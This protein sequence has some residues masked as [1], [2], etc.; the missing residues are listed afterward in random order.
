MVLTANWRNEIQERWGIHVLG[1]HSL[2]GSEALWVTRCSKTKNGVYCGTP[3]ELYASSVNRYFYGHMEKRGWRYG[4]LSDK[5]GLHLDN[6]KLSC[7]DVHPSELSR[8][9]RQRLGRLIR[10]KVLAQGFDRVI[11]YSPSPLMS[12]PYFEML[13]YSGL[14]LFYATSL[15]FLEGDPHHPLRQSLPGDP[16]QQAPAVR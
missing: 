13:Y 5:Y 9:D 8:Q 6:E 4:V 14:N 2:L 7:Y 12:I 11:F 3:K 1:E 15:N 10:D 16:D